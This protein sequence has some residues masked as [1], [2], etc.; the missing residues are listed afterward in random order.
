MLG[1]NTLRAASK[2]SMAS[3]TA[4]RPITSTAILGKVLSSSILRINQ[5]SKFSSKSLL[6]NS[7]HTNT[8]NNTTNTNNKR[9]N[10]ES[11]KTD[12]KDLTWEEFLSLRQKRRRY[13]LG[14]SFLTA[15]IGSNIGWA[16]IANIE[17]DPTYILWGMDM[18][19]LSVLGIVA[20]GGVGFLFG[21]ALGSVFFK[22]LHRKALTN[23]A[24]VS[25]IL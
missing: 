15:I 11:K 6:L 19:S 13:D 14:S 8:L 5:Q 16:F 10:I 23:Y 2:L 1:I 21:P 4:C 25:F 20:C 7:N 3:S 22:T 12:T 18:L 24:A 17:I 9:I